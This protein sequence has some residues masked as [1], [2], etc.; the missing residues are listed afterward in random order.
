[1]L[2]NFFEV[3]HIRIF[4][5]D[6]VIND[7]DSVLVVLRCENKFVLARNKKRGGMELPGGHKEYNETI[8]ETAR[9]ETIEEVGALIKDLKIKGY[10]ILPTG[11]K[12]IITTAEVQEFVGIT[13]EFETENVQLFEKIPQN[14]LSFQNGLYQFLA[15]N[16]L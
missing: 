12:T 10:Y 6:N 2:E 5:T 11:H 13:G 15:D 16:F 4:Y 14:L 3:D 1:M 9:R 8:E 7:Y